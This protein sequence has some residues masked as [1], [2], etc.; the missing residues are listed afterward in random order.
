[1]IFQSL[2]THECTSAWRH[3]H[4]LAWRHGHD[5]RLSDTALI[6]RSNRQWSF[7]VCALEQPH[8]S[9]GSIAGAR[10]PLLAEAVAELL[11]PEG[12]FL[13]V[14]GKNREGV[15]SLVQIMARKGFACAET[16]PAPAAFLCNPLKSRQESDK[17]LRVHFNEL[18]ENSFAL[19]EFR[20]TENFLFSLSDE[21]G[22]RTP[23]KT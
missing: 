18:S 23:P 22:K 21:K 14:A 17:E 4:A 11:G 5:E 10:A 13:M 19:Y 3:G 7:N 16:D 9:R 20:R 2:T 1:M 12:V 15:A 6:P 8:A